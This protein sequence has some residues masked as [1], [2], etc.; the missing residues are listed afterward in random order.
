MIKQIALGGLTFGPWSTGITIDDHFGFDFPVVRTDIK[1]FGNADGAKLGSYLYGSRKMAIEGR[2]IGDDVSDFEAK[3][4]SMQSA[5]NIRKGLQRAVITTQSGL[6]VRSDVILT[7]PM[8][9]DYKQGEA[10]R[11]PFRLE[12]VAPYPFLLGNEIKTN[13]IVSGEGGGGA[14]PSEIPFELTGADIS[15]NNVTNNGNTEANFTARIYGGVTNPVLR[16]ATTDEQLSIT[17][18]LDADDYIDLDFRLHTARLNDN[19]NVFQ[20]VS[21]DWWKIQEGVNSLKLLGAS[22][23]GGYATVTFQDHYLGI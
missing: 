17:Y 3:R 18:A 8:G 23:T 1:D 21:G 7:E 5:L 6:I 13:T 2:I 4:R 19:L 15:G 20:Y 10:I 11:C 16:N 9:M 22:F 14:V 12:M